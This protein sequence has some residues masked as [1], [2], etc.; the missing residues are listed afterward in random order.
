MS[1][2][3][4]SEYAVPSTTARVARAAF[5]NGTL[6]LKIYDHLSTIFRDQ[7]FADLFPRR[8]QPA[9]APFR[10]ALVTILQFAE[11]LSDRAAAD[12]VRS[13]IDWKYLLCLELDDS[14]F[15]FSVLCEFRGRLLEGRAERRLFERLLDVL[16]ERKLVKARGRQ[17]TDSTHVLAAIRAINRLE[18]VVETL[19]QALNVLATAAPEWVRGRIPVEWVDRYERRAD[20]YRLPEGEKARTAYA[21]VVG[22]DGYEVLEA[23]CADASPSWLRE[24]PALETL[25]RVWLQNFCLIEGRARWRGSGDI[26][27]ASRFISSP[28]DV[29]ARYSKKRDTTWVGYKVHVTESC[30]DNTPNVITD[31]ETKGSCTADHD[32]LVDI[33]EALSVREL[34]P[35]R[36]LVDTGYVESKSLVASTRDYG[37]ELYGPA[38]GDQAWQAKA[39]GGFDAGGFEIDWVQEKARCPAGKESSGWCPAIDDVDNQVVKIKF[40]RRDCRPCEMRSQCTTASTTRR[41]ITIRPQA[42]HEALMKARERGKTEEFKE[43]YK[44]R[45]GVEGTMSQGVR[46]FGLRRSR[47]VG[48]AKTQLQHRMTGAAINLVRIGAWFAEVPRESTRRSAF[49]RVM[50]PAAA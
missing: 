21:E 36:H 49:A 23:V 37:V 30:D 2:P 25:R 27:P 3:P 29:E 7:D 4:E 43:C 17:R 19:R 18:V 10:L 28:Y 15:D 35:V 9:E 47:Y 48:F 39:G 32:A 26:P 33:H 5:P 41:T 45:A 24:L 8:G 50:A 31:V 46:A 38:K 40:A 34:L 22:A 11:G 16:R 14:G 12:A 13:R 44:R 6:C 20:D 42:Q 1:L